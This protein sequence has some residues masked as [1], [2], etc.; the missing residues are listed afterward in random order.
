MRHFT[1]VT[2]LTADTVRVWERRH[3]A[4]R[5]GR[6]PGGARRHSSQDVQRLLRLKE[7][8]GRRHTISAIAG[9]TDAALDQLLGVGAGPPA[10]G[11]LPDFVDRYLQAIEAFDEP[12]S[13]ELLGRAA[14]LFEPRGLVFD[15][16]VPLLR[17]TGDRWESGR[18]GVAHEHLVTSQVRGVLGVLVRRLPQATHAP[19]AIL[20]TPV[21]HLH[22][23]GAL[24][25]AFVAPISGAHPVYLGPNLPD[26]E[27]ERAARSVRARWIG[28]SVLR[29]VE[30]SELV[31]LSATVQRLR[32]HAEVLVGLPED[33]TA[34]PA[35]RDAGATILHR[36]EALPAVL[37]AQPHNR[38]V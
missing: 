32:P 35:L 36:L 38:R 20:T 6:S 1:R 17:E 25:A 30:A 7:A 18:V 8:V 31:A 15:T 9:L 16:L 26:D 5:P 28:L 24:L 19:R 37:G 27:I 22:E 10:A 34:T 4:V 2:G 11:P 21:G 13:A 14:T 12:R 33:H 29:S 3:E 23:L